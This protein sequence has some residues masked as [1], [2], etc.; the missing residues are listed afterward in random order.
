MDDSQ[1]IDGLSKNQYHDKNLDD[2][3]HRRPSNSVLLNDWSWN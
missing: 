2:T 1:K 3:N